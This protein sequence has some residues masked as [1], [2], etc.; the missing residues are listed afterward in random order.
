MAI[1][2]YITALLSDVYAAEDVFQETCQI[3]VD[4]WHTYNP[5]YPFR[6]WAFGIARNRVR[7]YLRGRKRSRTVITD[8]EVLGLV[9]ASEAWDEDDREEKKALR[10]CLT[11]LTDKI[12]SMLHMRYFENCDLS[13]IARRL[14]WNP[15]SISVAMTRARMKLMEC[16]ETT[17]SR[18]EEGRTS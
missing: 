17:M 6:P 8:P 10:E 14:S 5:S 9:A 3:I 2:G 12:R 15:R 4:K 16:I 1:Y 18:L 7:K 11:K 13:T